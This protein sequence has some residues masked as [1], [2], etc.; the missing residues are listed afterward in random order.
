[1]KFSRE[2][3]AACYDFLCTTPPFNK[4]NMP[5]S[6]DVI[7]MVV[8]CPRHRGWCDTPAPRHKLKSR[9]AISGGTLSHTNSLVM[10]MAHEMIHLHQHRVGTDKR[11][12]QHNAAFEIDAELVCKL[13]GWDPKLF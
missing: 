2:M 5:E 6:D 3:L 11:G 7:F 12:V 1:V 4:W 13:H 8:K 9:I 10:T